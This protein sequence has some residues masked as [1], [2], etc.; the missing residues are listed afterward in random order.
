MNLD[1]SDLWT[2]TGLMLDVL[3]VLFLGC[4]LL[5][6]LNKSRRLENKKAE[7]TLVE[8]NQRI[9]ASDGPEPGITIAGRRL[10]EVVPL[11]DTGLL[12]QLGRRRVLAWI[13]LSLLITGFVFQIIGSWPQ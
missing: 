10:D 4:E 6:G 2:I 3:G 1:M 9:A 12:A 8:S 11:K 7:P 5:L 13:G